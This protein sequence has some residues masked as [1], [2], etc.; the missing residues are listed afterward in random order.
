M[1][2]LYWIIVP[3]E[4][5]FIENSLDKLIVIVFVESKLQT[6]SWHPYR[7]NDR[8]PDTSL[9]AHM[10]QTLSPNA[11]WFSNSS[12]VCIEAHPNNR[13]P[14]AYTSHDYRHSNIFKSINNFR[15]ES[16]SCGWNLFKIT[17]NNWIQRFTFPLCR[18]RLICCVMIAGGY[19]G[20]PFITDNFWG[21][22]LHYK[23]I[24]AWNSPLLD[25]NVWIQTDQAVIM[26]SWRNVQ[27]TR[28]EEKRRGVSLMIFQRPLCFWSVRKQ[29]TWKTFWLTGIIWNYPK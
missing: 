21:K 2:I 28:V 8:Y 13:A 10:L 24:R 3:N 18:V 9:Q 11:P 26:K 16:T 25:A 17:T 15:W 5:L 20:S 22:L 12:Y 14:G 6:K 7:V 4:G 23:P 29:C 1:C 27:S 19:L